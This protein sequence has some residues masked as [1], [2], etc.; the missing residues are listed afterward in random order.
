MRYA[1]VPSSHLRSLIE[2]YLPAN[3]RIVHE[4]DNGQGI[5]IAG[6]DDHG[7]TLDGYVIPRFGSGLIA[8][9][10]VWPVFSKGADFTYCMDVPNDWLKVPS[11]PSSIPFSHT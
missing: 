7:W 1:I 6:E 4:D 8:C 11:I 5:L 2:S 9:Q 3:Y 10:E